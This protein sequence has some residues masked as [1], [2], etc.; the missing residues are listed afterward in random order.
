MVKSIKELAEDLDK[1]SGALMA[2]GRRTLA[3]ISRAVNN[4]DRNPSR[5][6]FGGGNNAAPAAAAHRRRQASRGRPPPRRRSAE[7]QQRRAVARP[8]NVSRQ[9][10]HRAAKRAVDRV[11]RRVDQ[12]AD[13]QLRVANGCSR[14]RRLRPVTSASSACQALIGDSASDGPI[15]AALQGDAIVA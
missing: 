8:A 9:L 14:L 11:H 15:A 5:V 4:F 3:D 1:R 12:A 13:R 10:R 2:D 6:I 7:R